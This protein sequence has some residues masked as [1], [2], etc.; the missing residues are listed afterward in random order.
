[1]QLTYDEQIA[2]GENSKV[3]FKSTFNQE[4]VESVCAFANKHGGTIFIGL[5]SA[6]R[7]LGL[8]LGSKS[9]QQWL[10]EIKGKTEPVQIPDIESF[11][12]KGRTLVAVT[13]HES[14]IKPVAV[15]GRCFKRHENSNHIMSPTEISDCMLQT[16]NSSW[17][18]VLDESSTMDDISLDKVERSIER[19]NRRGYHISPD[20]KEFLLKNRL[21]RN[22]KLAFAA[23]M[24][25]A[26]DWHMNTAIQMGF[27]Q[28]PT[29]IKDRDEAHCDLVNQ[30]DQVFDFVKKHINC[31]VV[32]SGKPENDLVWDYPLDA[33]R[34]LILN[35]IVH[36]DYRSP[37]E[38]CVKVFAD[39]IEFFNPGKL[40][41]DIS[42]NDLLS[43]HYLSTLRNKAIANHFHQLGEIEKYGSGITRVIKLF[44]EAGLEAPKFEVSGTGVKVTV[45]AKK[46]ADKPT[47]NVK[48][49]DKVDNK[50][51]NK[52]DDKNS[53]LTKTSQ[54]IFKIIA[55]NEGC[56]IDFIIKKTNFSTS[57]VKKIVSAL[58]KAQKI[59]HRGSKKN[60][61]YYI[62]MNYSEKNNEDRA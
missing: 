31:A 30:V 27:F 12:Y 32:I 49:D 25:F 1:M 43:K 2:L 39:H 24:L 4:V 5:K 26:K 59:E 40:P 3:E 28:S 53:E 36:R 47:I 7:I 37:S 8:Q 23:E 34:E 10:N 18:Y 22:G 17:D 51:D 56:K 15:Q 52:V 14:A 58:V 62:V 46:V 60:G 6:D 57:Y 20:A 54:L 16:Q 35:M 61:G 9:L 29:I 38:S 45:W 41:D 42:I 44:H 33:L 21:L 55:K 19:I 13:I 48:T 50:V 11:E